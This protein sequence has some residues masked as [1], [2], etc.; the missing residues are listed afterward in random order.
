MIVVDWSRMSQLLYTSSADYVPSV[1]NHIA[2]FIDF[3]R[4]SAGLNLQTTIIVGFSLGAHIAGIAAH[5]TSGTVQAVVG[6]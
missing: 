2:S 6:Q 1:G 5:S 3:M 4:V